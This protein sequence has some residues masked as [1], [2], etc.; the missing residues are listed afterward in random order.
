MNHNQ[1]QGQSTIRNLIKSYLNAR[2]KILPND[3]TLP[4]DNVSYS[5]LEE[6]KILPTDNTFIMIMYH[7][8]TGKKLKVGLHKARFLVLCNFFILMICPQ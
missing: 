7:T 3:N 1:L 8:P 5:N 4:Q 6:V 2:L